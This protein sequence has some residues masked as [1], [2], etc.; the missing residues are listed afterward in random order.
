MTGAGDVGNRRT[1][2]WSEATLRDPPVAL[3]HKLIAIRHRYAAL[4]TGSFITLLADNA[5]DVYAFGRFDRKHRIAVVLNASGRRHTVA[6][7]VWQLSDVDGSKVRDLLNGTT[8]PVIGG[9]VRIAL[10]GYQGAILEQ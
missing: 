3:V 10:S 9:V 2:N 6:V 4:R 5:K 7:P 1:F 8:Y